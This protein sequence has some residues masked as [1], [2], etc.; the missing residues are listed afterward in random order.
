MVFQ[1]VDSQSGLE[2]TGRSR[3]AAFSPPSVN[4]KILR[5]SLWSA[6]GKFFC[7]PLNLL[8]VPFV[9]ACLGP[10]RY[11]LWVGLFALVDYAMLFELGVGAATIKFAA[12]FKANADAGRL[13][14]LAATALLLCLFFVPP[15]A[16][17]FGFAPEIL[18]ILRLAPAGSEEAVRVFR[19]VL[20]LF[21]LTQLQS[22]FRNLLIG[23]QQ[24]HFTNLCEIVYFLFYALVTVLI[25]QGGGG[26]GQL[27]VGVFV[28]RA[29]LGVAEVWLF[30]RA[31]PQ[32]LRSSWRPDRRIAARLLGYGG[33]LQLTSL[34]GLLNFQYDKLL[35]GYVLRTEFIAFYELGSKLAALV[36]FLPSALIGPLIPAA[37]ELCADKQTESLSAL[38]REATRYLVLAAAP[39]TAI[40]VFHADALCALWLGGQADP[41]AALAL[42]WLAVAYFF[43]IATGA[44][45]AIGRGTGR[46]R[47]EME[48]MAAISVLNVCSSLAFILLWGY[49]GVLAGTAL[50]MAAGNLLYLRRF[51]RLLREPWGRFLA[52]TLAGP[53]AC[54][55][56]A[57]AASRLLFLALSPEASAASRVELLLA[58]AASLLGFALLFSVGLWLSRSVALQDFLRAR[59]ALALMRRW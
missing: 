19:W 17:A 43:N 26:I 15:L 48:A 14:S 21:A 27:V 49:P 58:L 41:G 54:A 29:A 55:V 18:A 20:A 23:L 13:G 12:E 46:L 32:R 36:R 6:A 57:G 40:L 28:L 31:T 5:N 4:E 22:V 25:L 1:A 24:I 38:Y 59:K 30:L 7:I 8:L 34:A 56:A 2:S 39:I 42:R 53:V 45:N 3:I 52:R 35:I 11:G 51:G 47:P 33:R 50:S 37:S 9:L 44:A 16:A 10:E